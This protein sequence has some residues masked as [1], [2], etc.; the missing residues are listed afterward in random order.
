MKLGIISSMAG[1]AWG[2]SE[3]L[4]LELGKKALG[5]GDSVALS[6]YDWKETPAKV[7]EIVSQGASLSL[8]SRISYPDIKGKIIGKIIQ[9]SFAKKQL[10]QFI[11]KEKPEV[12]FVSLGALC[13]LEIDPLREFLRGTSIPFFLV[14]HVNTETY[15]PDRAKLEEVR[16]LCV[17]AQKIY[18]V[19]K[20]IIEQGERQ[21]IHKFENARI[22]VNPVNI[23][24]F[25]CLSLPR[26]P[27]VQMACV[28]RI[29]MDV[30]GQAL[31]LQILSS[32]E[33]KK[34]A[35]NLN[36]FGKGPDELFL[37][38][39]AEFYGIA[40]KVFFRGQVSNIKKEIWEKNHLLVMP[41]YQEGL[42]I[43]LVE[44]MLCGRTAVL[45]DVGGNRELIE[46]GFSGYIADGTTPFSFGKALERA[47]ND[48]QD[49][50]VKSVNSFNK[51][52]EYYGQDPVMKLLNE[53]K[54]YKY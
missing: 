44:A 25:E 27:V 2:G 24:K 15:I 7:R 47:W 18:F 36:F 37:K 23:D 3:E 35:W 13:D 49:W 42:P 48:Q 33:W 6:L 26:D 34:R 10:E 53:I 19:S 38:E 8:R 16:A 31:L 29:Q 30:K 41:S 28:G 12:L 43:V 39:L 9:K 51:A 1:A 4:W 17:K 21:L 45:T 54:A 11:G 40:D 20:R 46:D 32:Q 22:A 52:N 50:P 5:A 14:V